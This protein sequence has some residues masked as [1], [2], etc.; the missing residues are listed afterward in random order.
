[1]QDNFLQFSFIRTS[2]NLKETCVKNFSQPVEVVINR[3]SDYL[4]ADRPLLEFIAEYHPC[5]HLLY[6]IKRSCHTK[7]NGFRGKVDFLA[8]VITFFLTMY[9]DSIFLVLSTP[10]I[11]QVSLPVRHPKPL[12]LKTLIHKQSL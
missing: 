11:T 12:F 3:P 5:T 7:H 2:C 6:K 8:I 1:M 9:F 10:G 4:M